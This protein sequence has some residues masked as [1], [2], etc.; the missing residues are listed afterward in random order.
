MQ[1]TA[2]TRC[3]P[4]ASAS[5]NL[6]RASSCAATEDMLMPAQLI[7]ISSV[8]KLSMRRSNGTPAI[9]RLRH[10][11][12]HLAEFS[13]EDRFPAQPIEAAVVD[14]DS[15]HPRSR[16]R[17]RPCHDPAHSVRRAGHHG[18][19]AEQLLLLPS[20]RTSRP[21]DRSQP[22]RSEARIPGEAQRGGSM[23]RDDLALAGMHERQ[24]QQP[25][26]LPPQRQ[27]HAAPRLP[28]RN[29]VAA[30]GDASTRANKI[31][32]CVAVSGGFRG[33]THAS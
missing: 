30:V 2:T 11:G 27:P 22:R 33:T 12:D 26:R 4:S 5:K 16:F 8:P 20:D 21:D 31:Y 1:F 17:E 3:Q 9:R 24:R 32:C 19:A 18:A 25:D 29:N 14:V 13:G 15:R 6:M 23:A 28:F 7:R 10:V